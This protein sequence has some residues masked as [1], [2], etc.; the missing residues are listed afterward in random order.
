MKI[1]I[2]LLRRVHLRY[3]Y[4]NYGVGDS[5]VTTVLVLPLR[6]QELILRTQVGNR[7]TILRLPTGTWRYNPTV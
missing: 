6:S 2:R 3:V 5:A 4:Q 1:F 7:L